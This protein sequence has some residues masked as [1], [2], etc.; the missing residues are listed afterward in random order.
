MVHLRFKPCRIPRSVTGQV[1]G[2]SNGLDDRES[3]KVGGDFK[4]V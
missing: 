2:L 4:K 1:A 3:K